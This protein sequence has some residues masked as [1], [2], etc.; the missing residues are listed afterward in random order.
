MGKM[1]KL[2]ELDSDWGESCRDSEREE[3]SERGRSCWV[4]TLYRG[5]EG[6]WE[7]LVGSSKLQWIFMSRFHIDKLYKVN[8][9]S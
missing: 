3:R 2:R 9:N 7:D 1:V 6:G 8:K 4:L 5:R